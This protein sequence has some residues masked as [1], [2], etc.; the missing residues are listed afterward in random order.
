MF[1]TKVAH[2]DI[3]CQHLSEEKGETPMLYE[4]LRRRMSLDLRRAALRLWIAPFWAALS[5]ATMACIVA[6]SAASV[7]PESIERR[8]LRTNVFA[9]ER[10]GR[11]N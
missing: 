6:A 10:M 3:V 8:A 2:K 5:N 4:A 1:R 11:F 7:S 9:L